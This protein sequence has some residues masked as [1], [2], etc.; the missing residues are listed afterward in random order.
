MDHQCFLIVLFRLQDVFS[1]AF[2]LGC[3]LEF[4]FRVQPTT[5][6]IV[7]IFLVDGVC[8]DGLGNGSFGIV[9][10]T[11]PFASVHNAGSS[12]RNRSGPQGCHQCFHLSELSSDGH[13]F[14]VV[15]MRGAGEKNRSGGLV[16]PG[17]VVTI[18]FFQD[19]QGGGPCA[20]GICAIRH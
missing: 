11:S 16:H 10:H 9:V 13:H 6:G 19:G 1:V 14:R 12:G 17:R 2:Q 3:F 8:D 18:F 7:S 15:I 5:M 20:K 4:V